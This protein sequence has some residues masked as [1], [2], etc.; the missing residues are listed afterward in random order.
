MLFIGDLNKLK[1]LLK[2]IAF[3]GFVLATISAIYIGFVGIE[4]IS[5]FTLPGQNPIWFSRALGM[6][7][8]ATLFLLELTKKRFEKLI[9]VVFIS[10]MM[11]SIYITASRGPFL[12]LLVALFFY[13]F[14][15]QRKKFNFFKK[16]SFILLFFISLKFFIS[17]APGQIWNRMLNLFSRFDITTFHRLRAFETAQDL[18]LNNPVTGVGTR[19]TYS[20]N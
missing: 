7:L 13:F 3:S 10:L 16:L 17:I 6:S 2:V 20:L 8:L 5:R 19:T 1:N 11:F 9:C 18:F 12:A 14:I 15:L 4:T